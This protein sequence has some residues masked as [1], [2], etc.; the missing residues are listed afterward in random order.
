MATAIFFGFPE[1]GHTNPTLPIVAELI[2]QGEHVIYYSVEEYRALIETA[3]ANFRT[4]SN[5]FPSD[6]FYGYAPYTMATSDERTIP[7]A[8][9]TALSRQNY[10]SEYHWAPIEQRISCEVSDL[11]TKYRTDG[12]DHRTDDVGLYIEIFSA[13]RWNI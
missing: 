11:H 10:Q 7:H 2:Q 13:P 5:V 6:L 1:Q 9:G 8:H 12:T 3:G 4:Y